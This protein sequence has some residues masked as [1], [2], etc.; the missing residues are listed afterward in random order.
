MGRWPNGK[1]LFRPA[2]V[3]DEDLLLFLDGEMKPSKAEKVR[4]H[5]ESC[6][7]CRSQRQ[8][9]EQTISSYVQM[10]KAADGKADPPK[11]WRE[12]ATRLDHFERDL[13][14]VRGEK[15]HGGFRLPWRMTVLGLALFGC[16]AAV[17]WFVL[18]RKSDAGETNSA[19]IPAH[20]P[21]APEKP[22]PSA[23]KR[24]LSN[25][26]PSGPIS[27]AR[28]SPPSKE[29]VFAKAIEIEYAL[30]RV[31]ACLG[32]EMRVVVERYRLRIVGEPASPERERELKS[33]LGAVSM[34]A[35]VT[36]E[37][38][39]TRAESQVVPAEVRVAEPE[40]TIAPPAEDAVQTYLRAHP[41]AAVSPGN[42]RAAM[43]A[44]YSSRVLNH[45]S[46]AVREAWA[47][48]R[49]AEMY[50][51][52]GL[53]SQS[54]WLLETMLRDH[55]RALS[56]DVDRAAGLI[57]PVFGL[58]KGPAP[59]SA[60]GGSWRQEAERL[61]HRVEDFERRA[62]ALFG[63]AP[64]PAVRAALV[65]EGAQALMESTGQI[66]RGVELLDRAIASAFSN[67]PS[68]A[69]GEVMRN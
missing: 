39:Q 58:S 38:G 14:A 6:W 19:R 57:V 22:E 62:S 67:V 52:E 30:H 53:P 65:A 63:D 55:V 9:I 51:A 60:E 69:R 13:H 4:R 59:Q 68:R 24:A 7:T 28:M 5:L 27:A 8:K 2:H 20:S 33:A 54:Q 11:G 31:R 10:L 26:V 18:P 3:A 16:L 12:F 47:L 40:T 29:E 45:A 64:D 48:R 37:S 34:P 41:E 36:R 35:W 46:A 61:F 25:E 42:D 17:G 1:G 66:L 21:N 49:L 56:G 15:V 44:N 32:G 43:A 23:P 50:A